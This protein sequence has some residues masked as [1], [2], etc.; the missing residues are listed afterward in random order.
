M[1]QWIQTTNKKME[2]F[3]IAKSVD[4]VGLEQL[5][6]TGNLKK[7]KQGSNP[8]GRGARKEKIKNEHYTI[9]SQNFKCV[10]SFFKL[11]IYRGCRDTE[12]RF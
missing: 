10:N 12:I 9:L 2:K 4:R 3:S 5:E 7:I 8:G 1:G 11:R 6:K